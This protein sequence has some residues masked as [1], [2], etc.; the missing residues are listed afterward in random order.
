MAQLTRKL[1]LERLLT[2]NTQLIEIAVSQRGRGWLG[3][4]H[5]VDSLKASGA[6]SDCANDVKF[7][8]EH[9]IGQ[10]ILD[11][12][13]GSDEFAMEHACNESIEIAIQTLMAKSNSLIATC[14]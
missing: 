11:G 5:I 9:V 14:D 2:V 4:I 13:C 8:M 7:K 1:A 12:E 3:A 6:E 10:I